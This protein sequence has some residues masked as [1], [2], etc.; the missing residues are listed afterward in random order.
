[1][2]VRG[3]VVLAIAGGVA[4]WA[5]RTRPTVTGFV[6]D[7]TRPLMHSNAAVK[8]SEHKRVVAEAAPAAVE[9]NQVPMTMVR[10]G[11]KKAEV[12]ELLGRPDRVE[13]FQEDGRDRVRWVY[14]E[15]GRSLV[16]EEGRVV[17]I[18]VR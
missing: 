18:T 10:Q 3:L 15:A 17:S 4:Y 8:E 13:E 5:Y 1:M 11:M 6:D 9:G 16:F 2:K 12:E 7:L 14:V